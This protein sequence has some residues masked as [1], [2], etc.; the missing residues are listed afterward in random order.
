[1]KPGVILLLLAVSGLASAAEP[2]AEVRMSLD[3]Y[4]RLMKA[5]MHTG[6]PEA[7]WSQGQADVSAPTDDG[8]FVSVNVSAT[9][10]LVGDGVAELPLVPADVVLEEALFNGS[11][12][13]LLRRGG[14]QTG[15]I[16][17]GTRR[18][19]VNLRYLVP[20]RTTPDGGRLA[21][22]PL[23]PLPGTTLTVGANSSD[24]P[25]QVWPSG[26]TEQRGSQLV[27]ALP[28]TVAA[29]IRW[30]GQGSAQLV[31]RV[32]FDAKVD[33]GGD[34]VDLTAEYEVWLRG[35]S[36][37]VRL[38]PDAVAL[39]DVREGTNPVPTHV[40]GDWHHAT[41]NGIGRHV[42]TATY[43]LGVDR[44]QG[45]PTFSLELDRVPITGVTTTLHGERTVTVEPAVPVVQEVKG[46]GDQATTIATAWLPPTDS[47]T[48]RWTETRV[49]P[50]EMQRINTE[51]YQLVT[52]QEGVL[53]SNVSVRYEVL[54]GKVRELPIAIPDDA[55]VYKVSGKYIEDWRTFAKSDDAPRQVRVSLNRELESDY[56]LHLELESVIPKTEGSSIAI[57]VVRPLDAFR[58]T[59][60]VALFDSDK[61]GFAPAEQTTYTKAGEDALPTD[62]RQNLTDKVSQA[63]K[64]IG[65]PG[66]IAS[67][68]ATAKTR[69]VRFDARVLTLYSV[70]E[71]SIVANAQVQVE[72]KS[73][74]Q[75]V[76]MLSFPSDVTVLGVTAPSLNKAEAIKGVDAGEG[77]K[78]HEVRFTQALEGA[79]QLDVEFEMLLPKQLGKIRL[80]DVRVVG[81]EVE[82]GSFGISAETGI[83]VQPVTADD[84]RRLDVTELPKAVRL[85]AITELL[86]GYQFAHTPWTLE[87]EIKRHQTVETLKAVV[88]PAWLETTVLEDGHVVTRLVF[89]V[90]NDD[91][92]FLRLEMPE[93]SKVWAVT[94]GGSPVKAVSDEKGALAVPLPKGKTLPVEVVYEVRSDELGLMSSIELVAPRADMLV[95]NLQWKVRTP[96]SFAVYRV[97]T[98][99]K[100][101]PSS[102][103]RA[104]ESGSGSEIALPIALPSTDETLEHLYMLPVHDPSESA[105]TITL[106]LAATPGP[107]VDVLLGLLVLALLCL[108]VWRRAARRPL[109]F[110]G[111]MSALVGVA[112]AVLKVMAFGTNELEI[113]V[114]T[115]A[116]L[117][118]ALGSFALNRKPGEP[119]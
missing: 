58:E 24:Q 23:P 40:S 47:M 86:L 44:S 9:A 33:A 21:I 70:K 71:G 116:I 13:T 108:A 84:L 61:V 10:V 37:N 42:L 62:I 39:I 114:L 81:A 112:A 53:N 5:A 65:E 18:I 30:D 35:P 83:E 109:G 119:A 111:W 25:I 98:D 8:A 7:T 69:D 105:P 85:R 60:V 43:R 14:A 52:I 22:V 16:E 57:P 31:R 1:M 73:G 11:Q 79:I 75:D 59:G 36:A 80:P 41:V 20:V 77:R 110:L 72:I 51:T 100:E 6:G 15:L 92:Q 76:V 113:I 89:N 27:V 82:E 28:A 46:E 93:G 103:E 48:I 50:E 107:G 17:A 26:K 115:L 90:A 49:A 45:Q 87:L 54:R 19:S 104:I 95:T 102:S 74:R 38:A 2:P 91:R 68:V 55:V 88:N 117:L 67:K 66:P 94:A 56:E 34:A 99:L 29:A 32:T 106:S 12:A 96:S 97:D 64:H 78:A 4:D 101:A 3:S 118:T 63:F